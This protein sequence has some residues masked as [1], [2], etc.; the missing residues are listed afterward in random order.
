MTRY[1]KWLA[2][3]NPIYGK[4]TYAKPGEWQPRIDGK[5]LP[6]VRGYHIMTAAQVS[7]WCGTELIEVEPQDVKIVQYD[8]CVC[9]TW[10]EIKRF[11]WSRADMLQYANGCAERAQEIAKQVSAR[12]ASDAGNSAYAAY[13]AAHAAVVAAANCAYYA[14]R[15][16]H[17]YCADAARAAADTAAYSASTAAAADLAATAANGASRA[18]SK[19][20]AETER[21][22]QLR[23]IEI[24]VG[25]KLG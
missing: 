12:Y 25:E 17:V 10:R 15:G 18:A 23:W 8:K 4:G 9:R 7:F 6:C 22:N 2:N 14:S 1:Y 24:R 21:K 20:S 16:A 19:T 3:N 11:K 13:A 5:L